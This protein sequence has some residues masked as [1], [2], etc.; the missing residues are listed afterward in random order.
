MPKEVSKDITHIL[1]DQ[2]VKK[3]D[4]NLILDFKHVQTVDAEGLLIIYE[5]FKWFENKNVDYEIRDIPDEI[6]E[7]FEIVGI[8]TA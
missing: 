7:V 6:N 5:A 4:S 2:N 3:Q 8:D 1:L